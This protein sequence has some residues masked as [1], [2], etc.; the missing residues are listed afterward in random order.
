M[1]LITSMFIVTLPLNIDYLDDELVV[2]ESSNF[3]GSFAEYE[4]FGLQRIYVP[5]SS[6][7]ISMVS[8]ESL[9]GVFAGDSTDPIGLGDDERR[10]TI[11]RDNG[12]NF[13]YH[14]E[15]FSMHSDFD[16]IGHIRMS[17]NV[18]H[19][20]NAIV[21]IVPCNN[22]GGITDNQQAPTF[23]D[24]ACIDEGGNQSDGAII[25][26]IGFNFN[27]N[28]TYALGT[29]RYDDCGREPQS[30][31]GNSWLYKWF[32]PYVA[33]I[34]IVGNFSD[35]KILIDHSHNIYDSSASNSAGW[36]NSDTS[37]CKILFNDVEL[38]TLP[39]NQQNALDLI[40]FSNNT[41]TLTR[42]DTTTN[43][44]NVLTL[45]RNGDAIW[46]G[47]GSN[48]GGATFCRFA[49]NT[50][51]YE[52]PDFVIDASPQPSSKFLPGYFNNASGNYE[53][54]MDTETC[55]VI[56]TYG[57]YV[58]FEVNVWTNST[59]YTSIIGM[60]QGSSSL[61]KLN[62]TILRGSYYEFTLDVNG[63][64]ISTATSQSPNSAPS[65][66]YQLGGY[67][68]WLSGA[69][70][71]GTFVV[72][73]RDVD[74][75]NR[76]DMVDAFPNNPLEWSDSDMDSF[77]DNSDSCPL[78]WGNSSVDRLGC[79]DR[80]GDGVS[81]LF[82]S[83][84]NDNTQ[85]SDLD[86]DGFGDNLTGNQPDSCPSEFGLS[87]R[88]N[89]L[90]CPDSDADGWSN[91]EDT[92]PDES[93]QWNDTD[94]D[95]FGDSLIGFRGD[96]CPNEPGNSTEDRY[97]CIDSDDDGW[98]NQ[99][100]AFPNESSQYSD[101]DL[102]GYGDN[103]T[104]G[105]YRPDAFPGDTTQWNDSDNDGHGDNPY[106]TQGDWFPDDPSRWQ[107]SDR[108]EV[109]DED[110]A[111][112]NDPT[113]SVDGDG[114][115]FGDNPNGT[116][117]D[118][119]PNN[120]SEWYDTD[121]DGYGD[122]IDAFPIDGTQWLDA[123]G[124]G[125]GDNPSGT[126]GDM[127]PNNPNRWRDSD[128]DGV[129]DEDDTF[130]NDETQ[131]I[132]SDEDGY[133]DNRYGNNPDQFP[134]ETSEWQ[135]TDGDGM[136]DNQDAFPFDPSQNSDRDRDG[137]GD[138]DR[139]SGA[140]KFPDDSTQWSDIDGDGYGDNPNGTTPDAF[141]ADPTQW[142]DIDGDGFGDN[143]TGRLADAFPNDP[144]Q[145]LDADGDGLGDNP[146]GNNSD[147]Y[148]FDFDN[149]GYNDSIDPLPKLASPGD[150]DNDG[151]PDEVDLFP[152]DFREWADSDGDGEGD[153]ADTDDDNDGWADTDELRQG[154]DPTSSASMPVESFEIVVPGTTV[155]LSAWDL[156]GIFGGFPL[157]GW[158]L[159]GFVT[160][161]SRTYKFEQMLRDSQ[162]RDELEDVARRWEY[163]LMIRLLGPHQGIR[164]ERLRAE[165]DDKFEHQNQ[166]LSSLDNSGINQTTMV[167]LTMKPDNVTASLDS[168]EP[169][170]QSIPGSNTKPHSTDETG[171]EW[172]KGDD[173]VD[174]YRIAGS[175]DEWIKF[176]S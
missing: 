46:I 111:F 125:H 159:F 168:S 63:T 62:S 31:G 124:D 138:N 128:G 86:S 104:E 81:D 67:E 47:T 164:L 22:D 148:P 126:Q 152:E 82:D 97:G 173:G 60:N 28:S 146:Y 26:I 24:P 75:D 7:S 29:I 175:H 32:T 17:G 112:P 160:R 158:I 162:T 18:I 156:V 79:D 144:T 151:A 96:A 49:S 9:V 61:Q 30:G 107:D 129:A 74:R 105:A 66:P 38:G 10:I 40:T 87:S 136:G 110:D 120:A 127:F 51:T 21:A 76:I 54:I 1:F 70:Q 53:A 16:A 55:Q 141:I 135:D 6:R 116:R 23:G 58:D 133:G 50:T 94:S 99:N 123:D 103:Q 92:F 93:S 113:Q 41:S 118:A 172:W 64:I 176:E 149:D 130:P 145:W 155:G 33:N 52:L 2:S 42:L 65:Q 121:G 140:D 80:D 170:S 174:W 14:T 73:G 98:S 143:P 165:L 101:R 25:K 5:H 43:H 34:E 122:N 88:G 83:F 119:F 89:Y 78:I 157:F 37:K 85:T 139:G 108:D 153:N 166:T 39:G 167:E 109:A 8:N 72:M 95:G 147:P 57:S 150:L 15:T 12:T 4:N 163:M 137:F 48:G 84:P 132:D 19:D 115:G 71:V 106:G 68:S 35:F 91:S 13:S 90:G 44:P 27:Q 169:S 102:D 56:G 117:A 134:Y 20:G 45:N 69:P 3:S 142:S 114:D 171:Y 161:N 131:Y 59:G 154:T 11:A 36:P 77:G 100:D